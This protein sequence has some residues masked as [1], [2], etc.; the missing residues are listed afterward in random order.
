MRRPMRTIVGTLAVFVLAGGGYLAGTI[1]ATPTE[2]VKKKMVGHMVF[3]ALNDP[4]DANRAKMI[5][6]CRKWLSDHEGTVHFSCGTL[7]PE[8][9][10]EVNDTDFEIA[11]HLVFK[12]LAAHDKYQEHPR[13]KSFIDENKA[14]WKKVRVFDSVVAE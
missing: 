5:A 12:D 1:R 14:L 9:K 3:F 2:D 4:S 6:A 7:H 10:R 13:H 8:L 11:L